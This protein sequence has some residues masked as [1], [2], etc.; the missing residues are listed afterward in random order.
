MFSMAFTPERTVPASADLVVI[1]GGAAGAAAAGAVL[2]HSDATV[3][4]VEAGPDYG[5]KDSGYWPEPLLDPAIQTFAWDWGYRGPVNGRLVNFPRARVLGGCAAINGAAVV[6]G[7]RQDYAGWVAAGN[8]GW[9]AAELAPI[10]SSAWSHLQVRQVPR[11]ELTPFQT[12]S[13]DALVATGIPEVA[14]LNDLDETIG[15]AAFPTN[16]DP[17]GVRMNSAFGYLDPQRGSGRLTVLG[18]TPA[19][20][21]LLNGRVAGVVVRRNGEERVI[22]ARRVLVSGGAY[23]S[24]A[25]LQRS[26]IGPA[27]VLGKAGIPLV[28]DLPGVGRNLHDQPTVQVDYTGTPALAQQM[29]GFVHTGRRRDE[30]V[31]AKFPSS[32]CAEGF[33]LHIFPVGGPR[34][35]PDSA[36]REIGFTFGGAV[37][38]PR[39]RGFVEV[40]GP[41]LEDELVI[42]HCYLSD[43]EGSDLTRLVEVVERI[44]EAAAAP[45]LRGLIGSEISPGP[46]AVGA[47]LRETIAATVVHYYHPAG[48][49]K[50]G[51]ADDVSAVVGATG[52][53]HG[54]EGLYVADASVMPAVV[55]GNTNMPTIV[56]GEKIGRGIAATICT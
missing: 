48:S 27:D 45:P 20:R 14:D 6:H 42:D 55:S 26:G 7:S 53:V 47:R 18:D 56:I 30:Q 10:F 21:V 1:G 11:D 33:D 52:A 4:V 28:L 17:W 22:H 15:V 8:D 40:S 12:A 41:E 5:P 50:M 16:T 31:I 36:G 29:R 46:Q 39:S 24:P 3:V 19:I 23:G 44:R 13:I 43:A 38:S 35:D 54:V 51:P 49:C 9:S 37:L 32:T 25:L 34:D 2:E